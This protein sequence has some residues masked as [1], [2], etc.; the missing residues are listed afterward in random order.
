M[1]SSSP[2]HP[3][4][5]TPPAH[6]LSSPELLVAQGQQP[7]PASEAQPTPTP[8]ERFQPALKLNGRGVFLF[9]LVVTLVSGAIGLVVSGATVFPPLASWGMLLATVLA[10]VVVRKPDR[11]VAL[12]CGPV[13]LA[14]TVALLGQIT[15]LGATPTLVREFSMFWA[16]MS[17][18]APLQLLAVALAALITRWRFRETAVDP[19]P[20]QA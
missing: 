2:A 6:G 9:V 1:A 19:R 13:V 14:I 8:T 12:W 17:S 5:T 10:A 16:A 3:R 20:A 15:L 18:A 7:E 11:L 4:P